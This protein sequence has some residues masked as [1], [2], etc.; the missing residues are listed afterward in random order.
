MQ[1]LGVRVHVLSLSRRGVCGPLACTWRRAT[2]G[3]GE[4]VG[5]G[6]R[7]SLGFFQGGA[8]VN[9]L[10]MEEGDCW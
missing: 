9:A 8:G 10:R 7:W 4:G 2:A 3:E 1:L 5:D 6:G